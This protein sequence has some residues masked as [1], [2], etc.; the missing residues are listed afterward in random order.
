MKNNIEMV[1]YV[2]DL[3][4]Y[5][6]GINECVELDLMNPEEAK[7]KY[8]AHEG[9]KFFISDTSMTYDL[10][11]GELDSIEWILDWAEEYLQNWNEEQIKVFSKLI[12]EFD[13]E[14]ASDKVSDY[15]YV[16]IEIG[17]CKSDG[18]AVGRY[19]CTEYLHIPPEK[20]Y[21]DYEAYG[22]YILLIKRDYVT[23]D[24]SVIIVY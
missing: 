20:D 15:D 10:G 23:T 7:S 3:E 8:E 2:S 24:D 9:N 16:I 12:N 19:F 1:I 21:I 13:W 18:E 22:R 11:I 6:K 17:D 5:S 14:Y 4:H